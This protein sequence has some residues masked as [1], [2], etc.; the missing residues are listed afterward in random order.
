MAEDMV[1]TLST[2]KARV[3]NRILPNTYT[4]RKGDTL[5]KI[6]RMM[7]GDGGMWEQLYEKNTEI[8]K[9]P[10]MLAAG[11]VLYL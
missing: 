1:V 11:M 10:R 6:A 4:V 2:G 5:Y 8:L 3:D 9:H 7:Y